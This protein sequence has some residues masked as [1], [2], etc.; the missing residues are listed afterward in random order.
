M[1]L[2]KYLNKNILLFSLLFCTC[3]G[4][5]LA[6]QKQEQRLQL[7]DIFKKV[8]D[9]SV[10][11]LESSF[12]KDAL[13]GWGIVLGTTAVTYYYDEQ[14][15]RYS[16]KKGRDWGIGNEDNT[17]EVASAFN[18]PLL[19]LPSDTGSAMYFLGDGWLHMGIAGSILGTGYITN[20]TYEVNTG[21]ILV[22][23]M[24]VS[25]IFNQALKRSFGR[26]SPEVKTNER[27]SW[28]MFPSFNDYNTKTASFDG[29]P[30]GHM[31]TAT[32]TLTVLSERYSQYKTPIY[33]VGGVWLTALG[34]QMM[35][36]GV[37]WA[38]D[39]PLG[40]AMGWVFGQASLKMVGDNKTDTPEKKETSWFILPTSAPGGMG[41]RAFRS[42]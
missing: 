14:L 9:T 33:C 19:R 39:Y 18:V 4:Q 22:H 24:L 5:A 11:A 40:I 28:N 37:H 42:F 41:L 25:T 16:Q 2:N 34:F 10:S 17:Q 13:P 6:Q 29:M 31:M 20:S 35:N 32:L 23:G 26:E 38:S 12:S 30:S 1:M 7:I 8:P 27:G 15:Y 21:I 3:L 36:N